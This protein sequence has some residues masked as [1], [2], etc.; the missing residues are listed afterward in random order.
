MARTLYLRDGSCEVILCNDDAKKQVEALQRIL[1]E[2]LGDDAAALFCEILNRQ[3]NGCASLDDE[4]KSYE[5][6]CESYRDTLQDVQ[7]GLQTVLKML[8]VNRINRKKIANTVSVLITK[9]NNEL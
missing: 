3:Q 7:D 4:L 5:G 9:I 1:K 2:R 6:S 8:D